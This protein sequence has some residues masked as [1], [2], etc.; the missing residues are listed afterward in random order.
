M[1]GS[2]FLAPKLPMKPRERTMSLTLDFVE[3]PS[4]ELGRWLNDEQDDRL[5]Q[6]DDSSS[7][8]SDEGPRPLSRA[9]LTNRMDEEDEAPIAKIVEKRKTH[10]A[11]LRSIDIP[12]MRGFSEGFGLDISA[13]NQRC[14]DSDASSDGENIPLGRHL[15]QGRIL[16]GD[17]DVPLALKG[18]EIDDIPLGHSSMMLQPTPQV[19]N[20]DLW[21]AQQHQFA[22]LFAA[23]MG[24]PSGLPMGGGAPGFLPGPQSEIP[25]QTYD[26]M[27]NMLAA[28]PD[29]RLANSVRQWRHDVGPGDAG[30]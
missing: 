12:T 8:G 27:L 9:F 18:P 3:K 6:V 10:M 14:T 11:P 13:D 26:P 5:G 24:F 22:S 19:M 25:G 30:V 20:P 4:E 28:V 15:S 23:N 21:L 7:V 17:D 29:E 16:D 1:A 2:G